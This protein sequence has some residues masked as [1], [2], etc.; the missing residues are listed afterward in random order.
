[1][2]RTRLHIIS[3]LMMTGLLALPAAGQEKPVAGSQDAI[4]S[5]TE[6]AFESYGATS[7]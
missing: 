3:A 1:M 2:T 6:Q 7:E 5:A 4:E